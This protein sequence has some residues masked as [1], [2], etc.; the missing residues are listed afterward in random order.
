MA[1][2][3][4]SVSAEYAVDITLCSGCSGNGNCLWDTSNEVAGNDH[5]FT[6][7]CQCDTGWEGRVINKRKRILHKNVG[8]LRYS[9]VNPKRRSIEIRGVHSGHKWHFFL[10]LSTVNVSLYISDLYTCMKHILLLLIP[11]FVVLDCA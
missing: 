8:F 1:N 6:Q 9:V 4:T 3:T 10:H 2:A 5:F 7:E 11:C